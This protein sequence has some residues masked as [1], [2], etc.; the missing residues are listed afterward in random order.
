MKLTTLKE[1]PNEGAFAPREPHTGFMR[2]GD[3]VRMEAGSL[4]GGPLF[5]VIDQQVVQRDLS[6]A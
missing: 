6:C 5:G 1:G 2:F 4:D 3:S